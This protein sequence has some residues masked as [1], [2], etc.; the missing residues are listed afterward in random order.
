MAV[1]SYDRFEKRGFEV[2]GIFD[3]SPEK[4]AD[5]SVRGLKVQGLVA[6]PDF[7][8]IHKVDIAALTMP[9]EGAAMVTP[10]LIAGGVKGIWNFSHMDLDVPEGVTIQN[11]HLSESLMELGYRM[12]HSGE[13]QKKE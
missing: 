1:A 10:V 2:V 9:S 11:V 3:R 13:S 5:V 12:N 4:H 6:L 7:L 8:K